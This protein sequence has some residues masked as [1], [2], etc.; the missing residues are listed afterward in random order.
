[1]MP[2][3][4]IKIGIMKYIWMIVAVLIIGGIWY[5]AAPNAGQEGVMVND[6]STATEQTTTSTDTSTSDTTSDSSVGGVADSMVKEVQVDGSNF[7]FSPKEIRV[8]EGTKVRIVFKNTGGMH[9]FVIDE[10]NARTQ[11]IKGGES[12]TIE[13]VANKKGTYEYYC[14]VGTHRQMGMKGNLVVE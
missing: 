2:L 13:F 14:S 12:E 8:A 7:A 3:I 11:V 1:M 4:L 9:D 5:V 6:G 10:F